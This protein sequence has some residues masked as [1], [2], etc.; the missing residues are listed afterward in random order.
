MDSDRYVVVA[1]CV[2]LKKIGQLPKFKNPLCPKC[3]KPL[4][5]N[6]DAY[7]C[8]ACAYSTDRRQTDEAI[9]RHKA[10]YA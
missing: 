6:G 1:G 3:K 2:L 5:I 10:R 8:P 7:S 9:A 4:F